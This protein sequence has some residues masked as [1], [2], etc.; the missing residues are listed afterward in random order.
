MK[1]IPLY[2]LLFTATILGC[3][4]VGL[5]VLVPAYFAPDSGYW[6]QLSTAAQRV[7][8]VAI[9]NIF[10]GPGT[11]Y[12]PRSDYIQAIRSVQSSG[13]QVLGYVYS[14]YGSRATN[15]V[16]ADMLKWQQFY[17]IDGFFID[18]MANTATAANL[19]YYAS[20]SGYA[21]SLKTNN[22]VI[23]NP[24]A[25]TAE[26]FRTRN[27]VDVLTIFEGDTS[28]ANFTPTAWTQKYPPYQF[29][30][31][32]YGIATAT[33]MQTNLNL[34]LTRNAGYI[35]ITDDILDNPWDT[36]PT[37]WT[38]EISAI[39][40]INQAAARQIL[41]NLTIT[42]STATTNSSANIKSQGAPGLYILETGFPAQWVPL[43]TN[44]TATGS[45][46]W[47]ITN[48]AIPANRLFRT[49]QP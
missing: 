27:T 40:S 24:G 8:L 26:A 21:R 12:T 22:L 31:L 28:Y 33:A 41:T 29:A 32:L 11:E 49:R 16:K 20:L 3:H 10:N 46:N 48:Q 35:Y 13:G 15:I 4:A 25:N 34:A 1:L 45:I 37:Y 2:V 42:N 47:S 6:T 18:E 14:G 19:D 7:P 17:S 9:A 39:E 38:Q 43:A 36:L 23:G 30:H 44:L 5:A